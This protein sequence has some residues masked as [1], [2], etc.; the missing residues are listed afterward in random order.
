MLLVVLSLLSLRLSVKITTLKT[1]E[2][3]QWA[4]PRSLIKFST[5]LLFEGVTSENV[6]KQHET[7]SL[8][9]IQNT[10]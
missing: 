7:Q 2:L 3:L 10:K 1:I 8:Y 6:T 4:W 9:R 5:C